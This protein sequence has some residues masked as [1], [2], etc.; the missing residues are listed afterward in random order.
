M[1]EGWFPLGCDL[2]FVP[3]SGFRRP[4]LSQSPVFGW[5]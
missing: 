1:P 5:E 4:L 2:S 3:I